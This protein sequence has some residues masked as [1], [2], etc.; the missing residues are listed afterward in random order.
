MPTE[1]FRIYLRITTN[2]IPWKLIDYHPDERREGP[3]TKE[4]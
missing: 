2:Q 4:K 3:G 1:L